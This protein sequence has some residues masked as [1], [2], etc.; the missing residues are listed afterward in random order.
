MAYEYLDKSVGVLLNWHQLYGMAA[1]TFILTLLITIIYKYASNQAE[2]KRIKE[3]SIQL[4]KELKDHKNN[5]DKLAELQK[6]QLE[7]FKG[8]FIDSFKHNFKPMIITFIPMALLFVYLREYYN[9]IGNPKIFLGLGWIWAYIIFSV[10]FSQILR[11]ILKV[12]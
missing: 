10:V 3:E 12:H 2:L 11:K 9:A 7:Q 6:K 4:Q 5:P 8:T 1:L